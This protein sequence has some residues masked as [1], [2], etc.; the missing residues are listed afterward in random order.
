MAPM[1]WLREAAPELL[2]LV[3]AIAVPLAGLVLAAQVALTGERHQGLRIAA[4]SVL[5]VCVWATV[6]TA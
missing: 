6:L 4:A 3:I 1:R 2:P 5:G